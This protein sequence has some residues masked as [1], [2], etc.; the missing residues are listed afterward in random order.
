MPLNDPLLVV[1]LMAQ[2]TTHLGFGVTCALSYEHP[3][4]FARRMSTLDHLTRGRVGWNI[5]T[6]YLES[7][8]RNLGIERR[9]HDDRYDQLSDAVFVRALASSVCRS[10]RIDP[11]PILARLPQNATPSLAHMRDGINAPFRSPRDA[12]APGLLHQLMRPVPLTVAALLAD[13]ARPKKAVV[14]EM[15]AVEGIVRPADI[16]ADNTVR[17]DRVAN[18]RIHYGGKGAVADAS[19]Q[20]WLGRFFNSSWFPF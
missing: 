12:P 17:S 16:G 13:P 10:L 6:G 1:P 19:A 3:Y 14:E 8:A 18:A 2:V 7:A 5:V 15:V 11:G 4:S 9:P 20:G